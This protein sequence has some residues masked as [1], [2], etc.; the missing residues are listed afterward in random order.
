MREMTP[1][2]RALLATLVLLIVGTFGSACGADEEP[3][4]A[5]E[6]GSAP[7]S[8][9][10]DEAAP[11]VKA[12]CQPFDPARV[13]AL[14]DGARAGVKV[15]NRAFAF[16]V[17]EGADGYLA[18]AVQVTKSGATEHVVVAEPITEGE[19]LTMAT[20][21][22]LPYLNWGDMATDGSPADTLRDAVADSDAASKALACF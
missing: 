8:E 2:R 9:A 7:T 3:T 13:K 16:E 19:G 12:E 21:S 6:T 15:A 14:N 17:E 18:V 11:P 20:D 22:A 1:N 4:N 10:P 5:E